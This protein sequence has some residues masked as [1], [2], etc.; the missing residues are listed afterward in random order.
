[1]KSISFEMDF[2][3]YRTKSFSYYLIA[4]IFYVPASQFDDAPTLTSLEYRYATTTLTVTLPL[5]S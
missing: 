1:M 5:L 3:F 2:M 4:E